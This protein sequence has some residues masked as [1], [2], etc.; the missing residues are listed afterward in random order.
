M[1]EPPRAKGE[2]ERSRDALNGIA[3]KAER[4]KQDA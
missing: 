3:R 2:A 1:R 4:P